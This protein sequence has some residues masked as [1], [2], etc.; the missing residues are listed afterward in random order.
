M[1]SAQICFIA[2]EQSGTESWVAPSLFP[3]CS[4]AELR[5]IYSAALNTWEY[6]QDNYK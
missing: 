1:V 3:Q 5:R 2:Q 6:M 4:P